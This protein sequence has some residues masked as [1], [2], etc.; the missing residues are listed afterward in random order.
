M[1]ILFLHLSD[2]HF[3]ENTNFNE[4]NIKAMV[5]SLTQVGDFDECV[6]VFSGDIVHSGNENQYKRAGAFLGRLLKNLTDRYLPGKHIATMISPGNHD[7]LAADPKRG[8]DELKE[9]YK[10][11]KED[12][13][14]YIELDQLKDFYNF[15]N[16][17]GCFYRGKAVDV[18]KL[19]FG[20]FVLK[21]NLINTAP[22][23]LLCNGNE[24][25]GL[26]HIPDRE[27]A[28]LDFDK[29]ENYTLS[30]IHHS[31]EWFS[32]GSKQALYKKLY[33]TSDLIFVGHEH[34]S[35]SENKTINYKHK[36]DISSGLAL[37]GTDTEQ[38]FNA[39]VL[40]TEKHTLIGHKMVYNGNIY[41]PTKN[42]DNNKVVFSGKNKF[43]PTEEY[44]KFIERDSDEREGEA[45]LDY[46][47]FP[48]LEAKNI[49]NDLKNY[50]VTTEDKFMELFDLKNVISIEGSSRSGKTTLAKYLCKTLMNEYVPLFLN[51]QNFS[52]KDNKKVIRYALEEQYGE[53]ADIDLFMQI[54]ADKAVIIVDGY[55]L[56]KKDRWES[57]WEEYKDKFGHFILFCGI[58]WNLNIKEKAVEEL[59]ENKMYY[60]KI[61]PFYYSKER[62]AYF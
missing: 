22:F 15:A 24:D 34:F 29:Q 46:F 18:R 4:I 27:I 53:A 3:K 44:M 10:N 30:I 31:P 49:N 23:S 21:V 45:Y 62:A 38:G 52:V 12:E 32:D 2:A 19:T 11:K 37:Y 57:F 58:D 51:D 47:V 7:N 20:K 25:K 55:D 1:K 41:K 33:E 40:D 43:T 50:S 42:L 13:Q 5:D 16:R 8:I 35:L 26:H 9:Y 56:I 39:L 36:V 61:C 6:L 17:N 59:T 14:F 54:G 28:K 60:L 48:S